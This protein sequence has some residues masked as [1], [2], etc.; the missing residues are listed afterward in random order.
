MIIMSDLPLLSCSKLPNLVQALSDRSTCR[1][2]GEK[3]KKG[4]WRVG[5]E[6][7]RAGRNSMTWQV[8]LMFIALFQAQHIG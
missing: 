7:W 4:E 3:I 6:A 8:S 5:I 1:A 2:T